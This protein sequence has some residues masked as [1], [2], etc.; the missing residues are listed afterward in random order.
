MTWRNTA[1]RTADR[2]LDDAV[3]TLIQV[4]MCSSN[5]TRTI[6][7][8]TDVLGFADGRGEAVSGARLAQIQELGSDV[9]TWVWW[10]VGR[11]HFQQ[12]ELFQHSVP[13]QR[14][15]PPD[16]RPSDLGWTR[17]GVVVSRFDAV[18][19]GLRRF[20]VEPITEPATH[21]GV[22]R[23]CFRD[24]FVGCVVELLEDGDTVP[25][26]P[27]E[28]YF[29]NDPYPLYATLSVAEL[30]PVV[31]FFG[32]VVG[33]VEVDPHTLHTSDMDSLWGLD[34]PVERNTAVLRAG[35]GFVEIVRYTQP[36]PRPKP[37]DHRLSDQGMMNVAVGY[38]DRSRLNELVARLEHHG[39]STTAPL[40]PS[41]SP[42]GG[43]L[44]IPGGA[45]LELLSVP[46]EFDSMVGLTP[47]ADGALM[48]RLHPASTHE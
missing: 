1:A 20:G 13:A 16:W 48:K 3:P 46:P 36:A 10:L 38:R 22:R 19:A 23:V 11:L 14:P 35:Q 6:E 5:L 47:R 18:L 2:A 8:Y 37:P 21:C 28:A 29:R 26:S 32:D 24:P 33:L 17:W 9:S 30:E 45:S 12:L 15:Q 25:G 40:A 41:G 44:R 42:A 34:G 31:R 43:Y 39:Y 4:A 7:M 27:R